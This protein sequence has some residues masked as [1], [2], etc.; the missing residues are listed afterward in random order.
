VTLDEKQTALKAELSRIKNGQ[1]RLA[2]VVERARRQAPLE[3]SLKRDEFLVEGCL[4]KL[5]FIPTFLDGTCTF[6]TDSHSAIVK[7]ISLLIC[8]F[9]SGGTPEEILAHDSSFLAEMGITQHLT[10]NRRNGLERLAE[11]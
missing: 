4:A 2:H 5:W 1:Q 8:E 10:P 3:A 9:Y 6:Q 7:G 11:R